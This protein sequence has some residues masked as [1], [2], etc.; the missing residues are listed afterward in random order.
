MRVLHELLGGQ[1]DETLL[2][3][4]W[5]LAFGQPRA[6]GHAKDVGVDRDRRFA[7]RGVQDDV[8]RLAAHAR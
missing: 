1:F 7:E 4:E 6:V 5:R 8:R 3:F 2:D